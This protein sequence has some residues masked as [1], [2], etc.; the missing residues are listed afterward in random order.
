MPTGTGDARSWWLPRRSAP[1]SRSATHSS[2]TTAR[3]RA[4]PPSVGII[5]SV[6]EPFCAD[7]RRTR[8]TA[9]GTVRS[10]LFSHEEVP[11]AAALRD[12]AADDDLARLWRDAM[13]SKP[14]GHGIDRLGFRPPERSMSEIGG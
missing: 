14:A 4:R 10:C 1:G 2:P 7:C 8:L 13:W 9:Q 5:A 6:T 3:A 12:G 11:L